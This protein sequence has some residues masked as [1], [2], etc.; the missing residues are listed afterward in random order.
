MTENSS[1][2]KAARRRMKETREK[3]TEARRA[4][5]AKARAETGPQEPSAADSHSLFTA[6][7][8]IPGKRLTYSASAYERLDRKAGEAADRVRAVLDGWW[9][10][11][12]DAARFQVRERFMDAKLAVHLGAFWEVYLHESFSRICSEVDADIGNDAIAGRRPDLRAVCGGQ[13][14]QV[15]A[16]AILGDDAVDPKARVRADQL[17]DAL[18]LRLRNRDFLLHIGLRKVGPGTPGR[19]FLSKIDQWLDP[20]DP[21]VE[22]E[23]KEED[24]ELPHAVIAHEGWSLD[25]TASPLKPELRGRP[26]FGVIGSRSEG[27]EI[28]EAGDREV[29]GMKE[30]DDVRPLARGLL[31]KVARGYEL[32]DEPFVI[33][34]LCAGPFIEEREIEM[35]LFGQPG[36][37]DG[38]WTY[39]G[40]P[41][42]T[43]VSAVLAVMELAP[44]S[45]ALVEPCLWHNPW[46]QRPLSAEALP[47]RQLEIGPKG[48]FLERPA[49]ETAAEILGLGS[50]WPAEA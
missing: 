7:P 40:R 38:L 23:R 15:E 46:A 12:P 27:A 13:G 19:G 4:V 18:N 32:N 21:G 10:R 25:L 33:A 1:V 22:M 16:T 17:Y 44:P 35:A 50:H 37:L 14:F 29:E 3:Y 43:R 49:K 41:R 36:H 34:V 9:R 48:E 20:L 47:W 31:A 24:R 39:Q 28:F 45:C 30:I 5:L 26:D 2:K 42:Y 8:R 6:E 11:L